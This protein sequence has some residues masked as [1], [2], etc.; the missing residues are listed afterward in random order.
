MSKLFGNAQKFCFRRD[1]DTDGGLDWTTEDAMWEKNNM[2]PTLGS[3]KQA[4][5][6]IL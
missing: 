4:S 3:W 6:Y 1:R 5:I 2:K